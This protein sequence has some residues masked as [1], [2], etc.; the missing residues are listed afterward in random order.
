MDELQQKYTHLY[1]FLEA[2]MW[3][4][5]KAKYI[6]VVSFSIIK[7][8]QWMLLDFYWVK[9][10]FLCFIYHV[11]CQ[12]TIVQLISGLVKLGHVAICGT[13]IIIYFIV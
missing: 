1:T 2:L 11:S 7:D 8:F 3:S 10:T 12:S 9:L 4:I 5:F 6:K 13:R